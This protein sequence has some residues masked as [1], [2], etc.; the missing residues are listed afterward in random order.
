M[1]LFGHGHYRLP[2]EAE[3]EYAA[4]AGTIS[5]RYRGDNIDDGCA[6]ENI[7]DQSLKKEAPG[8]AVTFANCADGY[9][10]TTAPVGLFMPN[11]WGLHDMLGNVASGLEDC[12]VANYRE[13]PNDGSPNTTGDCTS[14]V[15]R[16][17][18]WAH[19]PPGVRAALRWGADPNLS[20]NVIG[21]RVAKTI[22]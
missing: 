7:A 16:G 14:R 18:S 1:S 10:A 5:S 12:Y 13:T 11:P 3:W 17:G 21:F 8:G 19:S 6:Y 20:L 2:T 22:P 9:G 4:R 15:V